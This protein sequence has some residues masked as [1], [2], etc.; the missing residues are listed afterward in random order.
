MTNGV[1]RALVLVI[2][3]IGIV[4]VSDGLAGGQSTVTTDALVIR[5]KYPDARHARCSNFLLARAPLIPRRLSPGGSA[6]PEIPTSSRSL[7]K[8]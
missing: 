8:P 1:T 5:I 2:T 7:S 6:R 4:L 3:T